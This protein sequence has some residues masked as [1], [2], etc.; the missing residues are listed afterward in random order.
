ME[1]EIPQNCLESE[2]FRRS[3]E[4]FILQ[5]VEI[6]ILANIMPI[7]WGILRF[8]NIVKQGDQLMHKHCNGTWIVC[9]AYASR[10]HASKYLQRTSGT[11]ALTFTKQQSNKYAF[12]LDENDYI[13]FFVHWKKVFCAYSIAVLQVWTKLSHLSMSVKS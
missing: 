12:H 11:N 10:G 8:E 3:M 7:F 6:Q 13:T 2:M 1:D 5:K 4:P 9:G